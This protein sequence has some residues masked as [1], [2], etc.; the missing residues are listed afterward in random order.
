MKK[1]K[2]VLETIEVLSL[3]TTPES[4]A[5]QGIVEGAM[6]TLTG[7]GFSCRGTSGCCETRWENV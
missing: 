5:L 2:L 4:Q 6:L 7:C 1:L 3:P